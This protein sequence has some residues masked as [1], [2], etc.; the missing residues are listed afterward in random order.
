MIFDKIKKSLNKRQRQTIKKI[1]SVILS[2][3]PI[4]RNLKLLAIKHQTDKFSHNY[5]EI[6]EKYFYQIRKKKL[7][8]LEIG[9]GGYDNPNAGGA[10]LRMWQE[11]FSNSTIYS[12]DI[13]HKKNLEDKRI[14]IYQGSQND[15][16]F[17]KQIVNEIGKFD[18]II[19]D[20]SHINEHVITSFKTLFPLLSENGIYVIED[21]QT[22]YLPYYGGDCINIYNPL[23]SISMLK[24]IIDGLYYQYLP[25][26]EKNY[27]DENISSIQFYP[28]IAFILKGKNKMK[29]SDDAIQSLKNY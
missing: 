10:S 27:L 13:Y 8:I 24:N 4:S 9:V 6:Y 20:G 29:L 21:L 7:K 18:I 12:I 25:N 17:L 26:R 15:P 1:I 2:N 3:F 14:R 23:T 16:G 28:D 11:Y 5:I 19:D 22:S